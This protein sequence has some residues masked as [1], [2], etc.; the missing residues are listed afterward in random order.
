[1]SETMGEGT[2]DFFFE[3]GSEAS[4]RRTAAS[5]E[6]SSKGFMLCFTFAVSM[7]VRVALTRGLIWER[8]NYERMHGAS[9][10]W[11]RREC[12]L[13]ESRSRGFESV[14]HS[15]SRVLRAPVSSMGWTCWRW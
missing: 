5:M 1:M 2:G 8:G 6:S 10:G 11:V 3:A 14:Q 12:A 4:R 15:R 9:M 7:A 13:G